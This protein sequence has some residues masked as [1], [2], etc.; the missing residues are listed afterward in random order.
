MLKS[1][2]FNPEL[3]MRSKVAR[4]FSDF[5][6]DGASAGGLELFDDQGKLMARIF[7]IVAVESAIIDFDLDCR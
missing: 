3:L 6:I 4:G 1:K 7:T 2:G 5:W